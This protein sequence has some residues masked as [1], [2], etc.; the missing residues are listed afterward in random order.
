[1]T[2][3]VVR[4]AEVERLRAAQT[5]MAEARAELARAREE[6]EVL[7]QS[8]LAEARARA[9]KE[10]LQTAA[11]ILA[12]AEAASQLRMRALE[13]ELAR[14]VAATVARVIGAL[15]QDE[16]V[17][18]ATTQALTRLADHRRARIRTAPDVAEAVRRAVATL[19]AGAA[20]VIE[21]VI[22]DRLE[23]GRTIL[24]SDRGHVEI[25]LADQVAAATEPWRGADDAP[26]AS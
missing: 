17:T 5:V 3:R 8:V 9:L 26:A 22:D 20:E 10:S 23:P 1:M 2:A 6:T 13:P 7:R 19:P 12:E 4:R 21:V 14:L 25:G 24:S 16:A 18:R 15:D 11:R